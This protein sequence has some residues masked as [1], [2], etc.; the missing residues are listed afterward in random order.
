M[1]LPFPTTNSTFRVPLSAEHSAKS[2]QN[3]NKLLSN[4]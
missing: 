3:S 4:C 2:R 1:S